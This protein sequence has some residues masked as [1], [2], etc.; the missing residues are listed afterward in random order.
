MTRRW[1]RRS[2]PGCCARS[3][4]FRSRQIRR[5]FRFWS[6]PQRPLEGC[7]VGPRDLLLRPRL[8]LRRCLGVCFRG[9]MT[10]RRLLTAVMLLI[11]AFGCS[12]NETPATPTTPSC[13]VTAG[14]ISASTFAAG[15]GTGTVPVT[16]GTGCAWTATSSA[17]FVTI[18]S[19]A[20]GS[21][22][23]TVSFTVAANAGA[24]RTATLTVAGTSFTISQSA[25]GG[26]DA[27]QLL[28]SDRDLADRRSADY[29]GASASYGEQRDADGDRWRGDLP[30]RDFRSADVPERP[31]PG[32]SASMASRRLRTPP[33][34]P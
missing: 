7:A 24:A 33:P 28:R 20:S 12:N 25:A 4:R 2:M 34:E 6:G 11:A 5:S 1:R 13:T 26:G 17:T 15:G 32:H 10:S 21:G 3:P 19:G 14:A 29:R 22:S 16:A 8:S 27:R 9:M 18:S 30:L 23:G 31:G